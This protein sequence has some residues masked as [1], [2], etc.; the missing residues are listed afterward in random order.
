M[1]AWPC[2]RALRLFSE[3]SSNI[4]VV[5]SWA[6]GAWDVPKSLGGCGKGKHWMEGWGGGK[7]H[8]HPSVQTP[9]CISLMFS[10]Y[11]QLLQH[12]HELLSFLQNRESSRLLRRKEA[13][14][15]LGELLPFLI[16]T[17]FYQVSGNED[18]WYR[19]Q[20]YGT[21]QKWIA[22]W[23]YCGVSESCYPIHF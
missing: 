21:T 7:G 15:K 12:S 3:I 13:S 23:Q 14:W 18:S 20:T 2:V 6:L 4:A 11:S 1:T 5:W 9:A 8:R 16:L 19:M 17:Y 22:M 10:S